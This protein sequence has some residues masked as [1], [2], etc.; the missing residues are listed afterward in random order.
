MPAQPKH[1]NKKIV[2]F[3]AHAIIHRAYHA[4]PDFTS[5]TGE[6]TGAL[7]GLSTMLMSII[8]QF[9]PDF[10]VAAFDLPKP[11]Y[12]HEA[13]ADYKSGRKALDEN[14]SKQLNR[15]RDVFKAFNIPIYEAEGFEADDIIGTAV[16]QLAANPSY[17]I[18]IA[19]GDMD[20]MQLVLGT[21]VRVFTLRKGIKD[22]V[23]YD[24]DA[25]RERFGFSPAQLVDFKGL[26][27][28][29]SDN[30]IGVPGIGEKTATTLLATF[31]TIEALYEA[32]DASDERLK[33]A[34]ITP[35]IIT[36]LEEHREEAAFSKMLATIRR[37]AP[38]T[39]EVPNTSWFEA[40]PLTSMTA[41]FRELEFRSLI[42]RVHTL[43]GDGETSKEEALSQAAID[44]R[45]QKEIALAF[46][47]LN[48]SATN[49]TVQDV[50]H[51]AKTESWSI[52]KERVLKD[53]E[54]Q[55][56]TMVYEDIEKPL[57]PVLEKMHEVGIAVDTKVLKALSKEYTAELKKL[58]KEIFA[59]AG[60]EFNVNSP[61][62]L[63]EVLFT[64]MGLKYAGMRKTSAG[65]YSTKEDVLEKLVD[66][67]PIAEK[68]MQYREL[69]KLLGTYID[70]LPEQ[71]GKDGR[72]HTTFLQAGSTTGRMASHD[73]NI[74]NI[75]TKT[76]LGRRI[77]NAF[78]A[79][80]GKRL[81]AIDYSQVELRIAAMLSRDPKL[82][83]SF[84]NGNDIHSSVASFV[85]KVPVDE[86]T[87]AM[88]TKA[89]TINFGILYGMGVSALQ[90]N[91]KTDRKEAQQFYDEYFNTFTKL[92]AYLDDTKKLAARQG[93]VTTMFGRRRYFEG[94]QSSLPFIRAQA[95]RM[96]INAPI[97]GAEADIIKLAMVRV[98]AFLKE[99]QLSKDVQLLLQVHDELVFEVTESKVLEVVPKLKVIM[100]G[101]L[102]SEWGH[103]VPLVVE[104]AAGTSWG[105][106]KR[107]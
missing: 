67:H 66:V 101:V 32:V 2:L 45:E 87:K 6:P 47:L 89:K 35:R 33:I 92:A 76:E 25:V 79:P 105:E 88:R 62:Q 61:K 19:S 73:P 96:A 56:L 50:L 4:L 26:R 77:R 24:E 91:L 3:D 84:T 52:A 94:I 22:T 103:G 95:E 36:L 7:Y 46:W 107:L 38:V 74:Q 93:Y 58:E 14:L 20:T 68:I 37:D 97:Q 10:M 42:E 27:G 48:S 41:L 99:E 78:V 39:I 81:L 53:I 54:Q 23:T 106:L 55:G 72:L 85:F 30:I 90:K 69:A 43:F 15:A 64:K 11:T 18:I 5:S 60:E 63:A 28:D 51:G 1:S 75:P 21:Q 100:E 59:L 98:A 12:R 70:K 102:P 29:P 86:V 44:P 40:P 65:A 16:T 17:E 34:G 104:A 83:E 80:K 71:L 49:P 82:I 57:I 31:G 8:N 9:K 13:Y